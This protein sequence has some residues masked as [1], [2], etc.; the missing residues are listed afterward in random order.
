MRRLSLALVALMMIT[1]SAF[2]QISA[3]VVLEPSEIPFYKQTFLRIEVEAPA[4]VEVTLPD[5]RPG[6]E[7]QQLMTE[8]APVADFSN[9]PLGDG[10]VRTSE[11]YPLDPIFVKD[12]VFDPITVI[13]S[14]GETITIPAPTLRVRALT[15]AEEEAIQQFDGDIA[16]GPAAS[17]KPLT[18]RWEFWT[19]LAIA[20]IAIAVL[21]VYWYI[22]YRQLK[23][24]EPAKDP[25]E[26]A[27]AR[28]QTL[29]ERNLAK[30]SKFETYYV[31][32]SSI[33]RYY[34]E[35]RFYL[36]APERTTPEFLAEMMETDHFTDEQQTFLQSFLG[37]CDRVK[38]AKHIPSIIDVE[39][40][41]V[42]VRSF[43]EETIPKDE[44][45]EE[46]AAA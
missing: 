18:E 44:P 5:L 27:L 42:Q 11:T 4:D 8:E 7:Q 31:D 35:G 33:L 2:A 15:P 36:H 40:S 1:T 34:V 38:F 26:V 43:V 41:F 20:A 17:S 37:L 30:Q 46:E 21:L 39:E 28:L 29:S 3:K 23:A 6:F 24:I 12:Y 10:R 22:S 19:I 14:T 13:F 16:G 25:W 45:V 32:L 9:V